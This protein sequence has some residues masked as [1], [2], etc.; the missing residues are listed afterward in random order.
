MLISADPVSINPHLGVE[1][2]YKQLFFLRGGVNNIQQVTDFTTDKKSWTLQPNVG[3]G[4]QL[5]SIL[6]D[7]A[8]TNIGN[9]S[10]T[11]LSHVFSLRLDFTPKDKR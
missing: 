6:I 1:Y 4:V 3:L 5:G 8:L 10:D 7:Y 9:V 11:R 2:R